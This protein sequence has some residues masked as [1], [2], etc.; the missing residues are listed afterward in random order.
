MNEIYIWKDTVDPDFYHL[1][2]KG[3]RDG[4]YFGGVLMHC[5]SVSDIF[6]LEIFQV[7]KDEPAGIPIKLLLTV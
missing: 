1:G 6:G 4:L 3:Q 2:T 5:D 7:I